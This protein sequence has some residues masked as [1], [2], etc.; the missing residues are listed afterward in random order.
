LGGGLVGKYQ[1]YE[2]YKKSGVE[3]LG[4]IPEH[5]EV[6]RLKYVG[7]FTNG[8]SFSSN[9]F[10]EFGVRVLKISN[11][12]HMKIDRSDSSFIDEDYYKIVSAF[13][14]RENDLVFA[15]TRP[16]ISTGIKAA[17]IDTNEKIL[18]NQRNCI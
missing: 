1:G 10:T 11:I 7:K 13:R 4:E 14:V 8:F 9:N 3:W 2:K 6:T 5:W 16:I 15:L 12:Q 18:L 17:L